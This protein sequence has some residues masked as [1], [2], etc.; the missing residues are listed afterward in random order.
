MN[1][2]YSSSVSALTVAQGTSA[3]T[4]IH[5]CIYQPSSSV[6][7]RASIF[8]LIVGCSATPADNA[9]QWALMPTTAAPTGGTAIT[10]RPMDSNDAAASTLAVSKPTSV[11]TL[12]S[13]FYMYM[14][15]NQ[16]VTWRW[17]AVP[18]SEIIMPVAVSSGICMNSYLDS[19]PAVR[20]TVIFFR[21]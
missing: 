4:S 11:M 6:L 19:T 18:G 2:V 9:T 7:V 10:A 13:T 5:N 3:F 16:R 8:D 12:G 1:R 20:D 17:C 14:S 21:E 15:V